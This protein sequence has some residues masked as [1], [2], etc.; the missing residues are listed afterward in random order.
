MQWLILDTN[1]LCWRA[2]H[3][4]GHLSHNE[5]R[6]GVVYGVLRD[7]LDLSQRFESGSVVFCFDSRYSRRETLLPT[8]KGSRKAKRTEENEELQL[9]RFEMIN[10]ITAL[11]KQHLPNIG[12]QNVFM[13][14]GYEADDLVAVSCKAVEAA[15]DT[16]I[17]V[18]SDH[19]LFQ[20]LSP[21][22]K[23]WNP[24]KQQLWTTQNFKKKFGVDPSEWPIVKAIAGCKTD[25]VPGVPGV[26]EITAI[27][28]LTKQLPKTSAKY[29][30]IKANKEICQ[31]NLPL[32]DLPFEGCH[33]VQLSIDRCKRENWMKVLEDL[34]IRSLRGLPI[35]GR[36][37]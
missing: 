24:S 27:K 8:Y 10:Q 25:D 15:G 29:Q 37:R 12:F 17:V 1:F 3:S 23:I 6:T 11:R 28:F 14:K 22:I 21:Q 4:T 20:L 31:R 16:A 19:D 33:P 34:G 36:G 5:V 2:F 26:G 7:V 18:S 32:V 35:Q 13:Q 9:A 30:A